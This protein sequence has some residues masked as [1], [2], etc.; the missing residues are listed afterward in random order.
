MFP[1]FPC[2]QTSTGASPGLVD[3]AP[4]R[5]YGAAGAYHAWRRTPSSVVIARSSTPGGGSGTAGSGKKMKL[6][7]SMSSGVGSPPRP[8]RLSWRTLRATSVPS[9]AM[10]LDARR[11]LAEFRGFGAER[12]DRCSSVL[13]GEH[14]G[15]QAELEQVVVRVLGVDGVAPPVVDLEDVPAG[16]E[17]AGLSAIELLRGRH[18]EGDVVDEVG[19]PRSSA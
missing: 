1:P 4:D 14:T 11:R 10:L 7:S 18:R 3:R 19:H 15:R 9:G 8:H 16:R 12:R 6:S 13:G 5:A 2:D 17:P